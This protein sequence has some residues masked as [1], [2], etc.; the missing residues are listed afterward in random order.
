MC[1]YIER[2][3]QAIEDERITVLDLFCGPMGIAGSTRMQAT[4]SEQL[5]AGFPLDEI[6]LALLGEKLSAAEL[7]ARGFDAYE[8]AAAFEA[9]VRQI[10][11]DGNAAEL[12]GYLKFEADNYTKH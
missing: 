8:P 2:S 10:S 5:I 9:M 7:A 3:R 12:A 1:R 6:I 11:G 4:T